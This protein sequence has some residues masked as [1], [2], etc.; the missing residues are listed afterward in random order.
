MSRKSGRCE[1]VILRTVNVPATFTLYVSKDRDSDDWTI[2]SI[3]DQRVEQTHRSL[4]E[5]MTDEDFGELYNQA[6]KA[7][8]E[9]T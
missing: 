6:E 2:D 9:P 7:K 1:I 3:R 8:D 4:C 5:N